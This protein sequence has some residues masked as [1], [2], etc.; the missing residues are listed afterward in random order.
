MIAAECRIAV[1][2]TD[3][4]GL[5]RCLANVVYNPTRSFRKLVYLVGRQAPGRIPSLI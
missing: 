2:V 5:G 1:E 3:E 4:A